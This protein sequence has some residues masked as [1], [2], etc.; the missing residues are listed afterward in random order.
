MKLSKDQK[1]T[2]ISAF[3]VCILTI[4]AHIALQEWY[5]SHIK[6]SSGSYYITENT[7]VTF[8]MLQNTGNN[9][10]EDIKFNVNFCVCH[11]YSALAS[12]SAS[13]ST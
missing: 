2:L 10:A 3:G 7:A 9:D 5:K 4:I 13:E 6:Y 11:S 8:L 12:L 1:I